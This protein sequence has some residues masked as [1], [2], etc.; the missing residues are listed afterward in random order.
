[1]KTLDFAKACRH[2]FPILKHKIHGKPLIYLDSAATSQKPQTVIDALSHFYQSE[3][4]TV[5]RGV[6]QLA[7]SATQKYH[8]ARETISRFIGA[9][10]PNEVVFTKGTTDSI[11]LIASHFRGKEVLLS[12]MEHHSNIVPWQLYG[13]KCRY[14]PITDDAELDLQAFEQLLTPN[15]ALVS[16]AHI[17][18]SCGTINPIEAI[19]ER[20]HKNGSLVLI[21]AAQTPAHL[22]IDVGLL[23]CDFLAFSSHKTFGPTGLGILYGKEH[24]LEEI[25]P[26][27]GG[28]DMIE[29]VTLQETTYAKPP[30]KFEAGTPPIAQVIGLSAA[31]SYIESLGLE[32][33]RT[34]EESLLHYATGA[35]LEIDGLSIVGNPKK[36]SSILSFL[37][38]GIHHFDLATFLDLEGIAIRS[39][40]HCAQPF[41]ERM[42][43]SGTCRLSLAP[44]NTF[45]EIDA[46]CA[47]IRK[48]GRILKR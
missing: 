7:S 19:I 16:I 43:L 22:P 27:Q 11:N 17:A 15:T 10:N 33:I 6:Y 23:D 44:F 31:L 18:N 12:E 35:L 1:M 40:H 2:D 26:I 39:G 29:R 25:T 37:I 38:E 34:H 14:I 4:G 48:A 3:Y 36:R 28:G 24:L 21:D 46:L 5:H 13:A 8:R 47:A 41:M 32:A 45:E 30:L 42:N 9:K 20:A